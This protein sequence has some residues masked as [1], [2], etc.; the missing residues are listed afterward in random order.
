MEKNH[1]FTAVTS[2]SG[3][4]LSGPRGAGTH[5]GL[6]FA[7]TLFTRRIFS[8]LS[9]LWRLFEALYPY[10]SGLAER[11]I[12]SQLDHDYYRVMRK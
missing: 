9:T 4:V 3:A 12:Y 1:F 6:V 8:Q 2:S 10:L 5:T 7:Y 11:E